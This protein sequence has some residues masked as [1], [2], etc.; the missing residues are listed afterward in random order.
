MKKSEKK[1][2][3]IIPKQYNSPMPNIEK[4]KFM[5]YEEK[6]PDLKAPIQLRPPQINAIDSVGT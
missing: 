5:A 6:A 3:F 4:Q 1:E 2:Q